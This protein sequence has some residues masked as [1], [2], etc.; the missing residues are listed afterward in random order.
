MLIPATTP[1]ML[2]GIYYA[3]VENSASAHNIPL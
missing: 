3:Q 1:K 2:V